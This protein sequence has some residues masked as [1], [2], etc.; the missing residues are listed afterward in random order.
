MHDKPCNYLSN[1]MHRSSGNFKLIVIFGIFGINSEFSRLRFFYRSSIYDVKKE[2]SVARFFRNQ[3]DQFVQPN[4][5]KIVLKLKMSQFF[6][7][8]L[9]KKLYKLNSTP[10]KLLCIPHPH[11]LLEHIQSSY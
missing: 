6:H 8:N 1:V 10:A 11:P 5:N 3:N 7:E 2:L 4:S 9:L